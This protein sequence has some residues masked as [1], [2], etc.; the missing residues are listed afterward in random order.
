MPEVTKVIGNEEKI[1]PASW[2]GT[3]V[4]VG[5]IMTLNKAC[6]KGR[7]RRSTITRQGICSGADRL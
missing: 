5:D 2:A 6:R 7:R 3:G 1:N 4:D